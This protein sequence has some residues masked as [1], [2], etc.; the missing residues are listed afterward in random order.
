MAISRPERWTIGKI[1]GCLLKY[2]Y[3]FVFALFLFLIFPLSSLDNFPFAASYGHV[4]EF[5]PTKKI[6]KLEFSTSRTNL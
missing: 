6:D 2:M 1:A 4:T 5:R 3:T